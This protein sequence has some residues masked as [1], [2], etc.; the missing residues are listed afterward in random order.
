[1]FVIREINLKSLDRC[2]ITYKIFVTLNP[3]RKHKIL[4]FF[5]VADWGTMGRIIIKTRGEAF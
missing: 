5:T 3:S 1:M 4:I 2:T